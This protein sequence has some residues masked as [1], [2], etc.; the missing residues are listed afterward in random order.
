M[1]TSTTHNSS[2]HSFGKRLLA[3]AIAS[4]TLASASSWAQIEEMLVTAQRTS[5]SIMETPV[6]MTALSG[7]GLRDSGVSNV[8]QLT[9]V[10]PNLSIDSSSDFFIT[11]R[12]VTSN[13]ATEKGDPSVA[14]MLDGVYIARPQAQNV[15]FFDIDRVEVL[16]GPQGTLWG[17]NTTAG[18]LHVIAKK[19]TDQYEGALNTTLGDYNTRQADG[20]I[21]LPVNDD[22][23]VRASFSF[24]HRD[25]FVETELPE[26]TEPTAFG[27]DP[28]R[29]NLAFRLQA[30]YDI[31]DT[32]SL[33]LRGDYASMQGSSGSN[34]AIFTGSLYDKTQ[35]PYRQLGDG[36]EDMRTKDYTNKVS[37]AIDND[38]W[39][40]TAELNWEL[41]DID[42]TYLGSYREMNR[43]EGYPTN[44][45]FGSVDAY[46]TGEYWQNSQELRFAYNSDSLTVQTGLY[47]FEEESGL[48]LALFDFI[49]DVL[50]PVFAF[51]QDPT[52]AESYAAFGQ[53]T[54]S[55][56]PEFKITA[57]VRYSH[58]DKS[59]TGATVFGQTLEFNPE[60]DSRL[61]NSAQKSWA[62]TTWRLGADYDLS[63]DTLLYGSV[64]TGYKAGGF[65]DGC[66]EG[67][68]DRNGVLCNQIV[69]LDDLYYEPEQLTAYELGVKTDLFDNTLRLSGAAF[70]YDYQDMQLTASGEVSGAPSQITDNAGKSNVKGIELEGTYAPAENHRF[71]LAFTLLR[72][73]YDEY[74]A[75]GTVDFSGRSLDRSPDMTASI[76]YT[77]THNLASGAFINYS[78]R[79]RYSDSY[80]V[81]VIA[82]QYEQP[83][84]TKTNLSATYNSPDESWYLRAF[85]NNLE[86]E[87]TLSVVNSYGFMWGSEP[88]T[89]GIGAGIH[90]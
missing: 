14:F 26:G 90:F 75:A 47:Y 21:N 61:S 40:I 3:I 81:T 85:A 1:K 34:E 19:P 69:N 80:L 46:F 37:P 8:R 48:M 31:S 5:S 77:F 76:G 64:A 86:N 55:L 71:D 29:D 16:R 56:T 66:E 72:A 54:Y 33:L 20:F 17:R 27:D 9:D 74:M 44:I 2:V 79:S 41:D 62:K 45:G 83:S 65:G 6:A 28:A 68:T 38:T 53:G 63:D 12:G 87:V 51:P 7:D 88:R 42:V 15:T 82:E 24:D 57:G 89:V 35:T 60:T 22:L 52:T 25:S 59:R 67:T 39:G 43:S 78:V 13:D 32:V 58:D 11:I 73:E 50:P 84:Y 4:A 49:P 18:L 23:A 70:L 36:S 30:A 10:I